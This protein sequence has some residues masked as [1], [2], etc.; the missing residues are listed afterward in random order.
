MTRLACPTC[1]TDDKLSSIEAAQLG[2]PIAAS[3]G[4]AGRGIC[5]T[6]E[7]Y[8][9]VDEGTQFQSEFHCFPDADTIRYPIA[10]RPG[11]LRLLGKEGR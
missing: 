3:E 10:Q 8:T 11:Q 5:Y 2:Y 9:V 4:P 7:S 6:G 1:G